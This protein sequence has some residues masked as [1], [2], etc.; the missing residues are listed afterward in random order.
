MIR[1]ST[2]FG[3]GTRRAL[4]ICSSIHTSTASIRL[5][6]GQWQMETAWN[7]PNGSEISD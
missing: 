5:A 6:A 4:Q 7:V 1:L 2:F 3:L